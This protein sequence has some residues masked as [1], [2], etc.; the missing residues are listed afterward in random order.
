MRSTSKK[1]NTRVKSEKTTRRALLALEARAELTT[2]V[3]NHEAQAALAKRLATAMYAYLDE[4]YGDIYESL[5]RDIIRASLNLPADT[6]AE[7]IE[8]IFEH[9]QV[10]LRHQQDN[11]KLQVVKREDL[12]R[13]LRHRS[14]SEPIDVWH[15][16]KDIREREAEQ[17]RDV[18]WVDQVNSHLKYGF[19]KSGSRSVSKS[20]AAV[21]PSTTQSTSA[22]V[23]RDP[24][25]S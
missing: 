21:I 13:D 14:P 23:S 12:L 22:P 1:T 19:K 24:D 18:S 2:P 10:V 9:W 25:L 7:A 11:R 15:N 17:V 8:E 5:N 16:Q 20:S 6:A 3:E 4:R